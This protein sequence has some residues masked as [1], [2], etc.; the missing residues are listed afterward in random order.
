MPWAGWLGDIDISNIFSFDFLKQIV[1][2]T[3]LIFSHTHEL[4]TDLE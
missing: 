1:N 4:N 2:Q 3:Q